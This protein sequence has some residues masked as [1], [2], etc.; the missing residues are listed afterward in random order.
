MKCR[1]VKLS[2]FSGGKASV[3]SVIMND[4]QQTLLDKFIVENISSFESEIKDIAGRI[5]TIGKSTGI[6]E[7]YI[8]KFEGSLGDGV[9]ALYD[10]P[11]ADL[12]LYCISFGSQLIIIGGGGPKPKSIRTFQEDEKLR[13]ENFFLRWLSQKITER[14][15]DK[16]IVFINEGLEFEGNLEFQDFDEE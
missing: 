8:K 7:G 6:R 13:E 12:R 11:N 1:L 9:C 10:K 2:K 4:E 5:K 15:S 16:E 14:I 3:Y